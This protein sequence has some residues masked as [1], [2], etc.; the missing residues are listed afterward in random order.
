MIATH[1][2]VYYAKDEGKMKILC[3][4]PSC[5]KWSWVESTPKHLALCFS[6]GNSSDLSLRMYKNI[7]GI[8]NDLKER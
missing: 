2:H 8:V 4:D 1:R 3:Q 6:L 7:N 5:P